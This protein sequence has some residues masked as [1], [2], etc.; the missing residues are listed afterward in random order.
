MSDTAQLA[1]EISSK[2]PAGQLN[3]VCENAPEGT[4][5]DGVSYKDLCNKCLNVDTNAE[6]QKACVAGVVAGFVQ[7]RQSGAVPQQ[8]ADKDATALSACDGNP[9]SAE[10]LGLGAGY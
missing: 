1:R 6:M 9:D 2:L 8:Q 10:C 4:N 3:L 5:Q 7:D